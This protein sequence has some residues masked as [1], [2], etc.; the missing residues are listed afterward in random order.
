MQTSL[1]RALLPVFCR[2]VCVAAACVLMIAGGAAHA[3]TT[4]TY[5]VPEAAEVNRFLSALGSTI[6]I[7]TSV[8]VSSS[9]PDGAVYTFANGIAGTVQGQQILVTSIILRSANLRGTLTN[10]NLPN[11]TV[12]NLFMNQLKGGIPNFNLPNLTYLDI[13]Q[14]QLIGTIPNFNL[15]SLQRLNLTSNQLTGTIPNF[16]LPNLTELWLSYNQLTGAIPNFNLRS[17][18]QLSISFNQLTGTIPNFNLPNLRILG[19]SD[20]QLTGVIPNF[21]LPN[22]T[23]IGLSNNQLTGAIP[24]FNLP[25]L[26]TLWLSQ[27]QLTGTIPNFNLP[28]LRILWLSQNRLTSEVPNFNLPNLEDLFVFQNQLAGAIPNF[29]LPNLRQLSFSNNQLTGAIPNFNLPNVQRVYLDDNQLTGTIPNFNLPNLRLLDLSNN[30]LIST[31][32]NFNLANLDSLSLSNNQLIGTI[33]NFN[34]PNLQYLFLGSNRLARCEIRW[35]AMPNLVFLRLEAN[36][37]LFSDL[38]PPRRAFLGA[39]YTYTPQDTLLPLLTLPRRAGDP[40]GSTVL[41]VSV[42]GTQTQY[43]WLRNG[44]EVQKSSDSTIIIMPNDNAALYSCEMTNTLLPGLTLRT[45]ARTAT[46]IAAPQNLGQEQPERSLSLRVHPNPS[47]GA[48]TVEY[49]AGYS[50][51]VAQW[52][53]VEVYSVMGQKVLTVAE[54]QASAGRAA[55]AVD[56]SAYPSGTYTVRLQSAGMVTCAMLSLLK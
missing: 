18:Q 27:N 7:P 40:T 8:S 37:L 6:T 46:S 16:N 24:N 3:Q 26:S 31:I 56:M 33:P 52:V 4:A 9:L 48:F 36:K 54:G 34:L 49:A 29:N 47:T 30:R 22:L 41:A 11:L 17:L 28:N 21:N 51:P 20:N 39:N 25:N 45:A 53:T 43:R 44:V 12:L 42:G 1:L 38:E 35:S 13:S 23:D 14:N 5:T 10:P 15:P 32:P 55:F 19:I 2:R 50:V